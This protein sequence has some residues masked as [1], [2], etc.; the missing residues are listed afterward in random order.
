LPLLTLASFDAKRPAAHWLR[1]HGGIFR[2]IHL[3]SFIR[4]VLYSHWSRC[5]LGSFDTTSQQLPAWFPNWVRLAESRCPLATGEQPGRSERTEP[6]GATARPSSPGGGNGGGILQGSRVCE[7]V[8]GPAVL[9][10]RQLPIFKP[11]QMCCLNIIQAGFVRV[12]HK[13]AHPVF[14]YF[15]PDEDSGLRP[16]VCRLEATSTSVCGRIPATATIVIRRA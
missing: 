7:A 1:F 16:G 2:S 13:R 5:K 12:K 9:I 3:K 14:A 11:L 4:K 10:D 8:S 6:R 15:F